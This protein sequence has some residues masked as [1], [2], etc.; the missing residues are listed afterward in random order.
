MEQKRIINGVN[1]A[2]KAAQPEDLNA[3]PVKK[4]PNSLTSFLTSVLS[5]F[6][7]MVSPIKDDTRRK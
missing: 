2:G 1:Q 6:G 7:N 5:A 4:S 3:R